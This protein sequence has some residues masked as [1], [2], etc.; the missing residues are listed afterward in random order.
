MTQISSLRWGRFHQDPWPTI[1]GWAGFVSYLFTTTLLIAAVYL[2]FQAQVRPHVNQLRFTSCS[3]EVVGHRIDHQII[4]GTQVAFP[5]VLYRY[6]VEGKNYLGSIVRSS[7]YICT[8]EG[9]GEAG[10]DGTEAGEVRFLG[11]NADG[12]A[13]SFMEAYPVGL[14]VTAWVSPLN[15]A[16][17]VLIP[18]RLDISPFLL[19]MIPTIFRPFFWLF[20]SGSLH[21]LTGR[22]RWRWIAIGWALLVLA[23]LSPVFFQV[24]EFLDPDS[25]LQL[26][27]WLRFGILFAAIVFVSSALPKAFRGGMFVGQVLSLSVADGLGAI[28]AIFLTRFPGVFGSNPNSD[29]ILIWAVEAGVMFGI[30]LGV[31]IGIAA[32]LGAIWIR[33]IE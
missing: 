16:E 10:S 1:A 22:P 3:A 29:S 30:V 15:H 9:P 23:G 12:R 32:A 14:Q 17:A 13:A 8:M 19:T 4:A 33:P 20:L 24:G 6:S 26:W 5:R 2:L 18:Q 27:R 25:P 11:A 7:Q 31:V 28:A 21:N